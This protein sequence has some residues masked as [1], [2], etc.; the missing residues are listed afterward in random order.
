MISIRYQELF[1]E[2]KYVVLYVVQNIWLIIVKK[3]WQV[4]KK[5]KLWV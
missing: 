1:I 4:C 3:Y 5:T 2:K